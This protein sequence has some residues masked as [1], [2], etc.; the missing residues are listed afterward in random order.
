MPITVFFSYFPIELK[1]HDVCECLNTGL[2]SYEYLDKKKFTERCVINLGYILF[3]VITF[4]MGLYCDIMCSCVCI[5]ECGGLLRAHSVF[6]LLLLA[7]L[8]AALFR[9]WLFILMFYAIQ[10]HKKK[11]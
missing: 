4:F 5:V 8:I 10:F 11:T 1:S 7:Y 9:M 2:E 6:G 3:S